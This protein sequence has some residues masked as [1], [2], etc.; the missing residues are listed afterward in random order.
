M[1]SCEKCWGDAYFRH[2]VTGK[3]QTECYRELLKERKDNPCS[4]EE[5]A[6]QWWDEE[7]K[8]DKRITKNLSR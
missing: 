2:R 3:S 6:G 1:P 5:Q 4:P 7:T 8:S